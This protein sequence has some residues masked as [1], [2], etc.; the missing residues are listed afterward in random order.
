MHGWLNTNKSEKLFFLNLILTKQPLKL[1]NLPRMLFQTNHKLFG[2]MFFYI[3]QLELKVI[4]YIP[5]LGKWLI[6]QGNYNEGLDHGWPFM[7]SFNRRR[8]RS[9]TFPSRSLDC[10]RPNKLGKTLVFKQ[11]GNPCFGY[12]NQES[13]RIIKNHQETIVVFF[14]FSNHIYIKH[15]C[16]LSSPWKQV[17]QS[18][19]NCT[20]PSKLQCLG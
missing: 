16:S 13:S 9:A 3:S 19:G 20:T 17:S 10:F 6:F 15:R 1:E 11:F 2:L 18:P 14:S 7:A 12:W 4:P 5:S 8:L